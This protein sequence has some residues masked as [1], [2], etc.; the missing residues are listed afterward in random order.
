MVAF[1]YLFLLRLFNRGVSGSCACGRPANICL[2]GKLYGGG[3]VSGPH[4]GHCDVTLDTAGSGTSDM[5]M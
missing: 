1:S 5:D 4:S 2:V 3:D